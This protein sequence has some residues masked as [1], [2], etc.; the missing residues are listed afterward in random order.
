MF[1]RNY[2]MLPFR[3]IKKKTTEII[4]NTMMQPGQFYLLKSIRKNRNII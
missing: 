2:N 3:F 1:V 4:E